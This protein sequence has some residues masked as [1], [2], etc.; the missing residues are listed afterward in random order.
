M[1]GH[2]SCPALVWSDDACRGARLSITTSVKDSLLGGKG[3]RV[4]P[5]LFACVRKCFLVFFEVQVPRCWQEVLQGGWDTTSSSW[6]QQ[7]YYKAHKSRS[8][9]SRVL[10]KV[11]KKGQKTLGRQQRRKK[12][13]VRNSKGNIKVRRGEGAPLCSATCAPGESTPEQRS[14]RRGRVWLRGMSVCCDP[15]RAAPYLDEECNLQ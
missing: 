5:P 1:F 11:G 2:T 12:T 10:G 14:S 6:L 7:T 13:E 9:N 4:L 15:S 8:Q 3:C